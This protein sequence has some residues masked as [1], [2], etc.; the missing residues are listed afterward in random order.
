MCALFS[1]KRLPVSKFWIHL[2]VSQILTCTCKRAA[3]TCKGQSKERS[4]YSSS[5]I[6]VGIRLAAWPGEEAM[7]QSQQ[8]LRYAP[9]S[10]LG[11]A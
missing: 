4:L 3:R 7:R 8:K 9:L 10:G 6:Q 5:E 11:F 2:R 1:N